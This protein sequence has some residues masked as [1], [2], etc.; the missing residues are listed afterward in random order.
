M[1]WGQCFKRAGLA[2]QHKLL[3]VSLPGG[4]LGTGQAGMKGR[5]A[6][7]REPIMQQVLS[8]SGGIS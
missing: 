2:S 3:A 6:S 1:G 4:A 5:S 8:T 7:G